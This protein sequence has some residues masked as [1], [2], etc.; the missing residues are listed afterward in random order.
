MAS[1]SSLSKWGAFSIFFW[2]ALSGCSSE[3]HLRKAIAKNP[4]ILQP[5]E[6]VLID[7]MVITPSLRVDTLAYFRTDTITIEKD[8]L[9]VQIK[10]IHDTLRITAECQSDTVRIVK[11]IALPPV[12]K[13]APRKWWE[14]VPLPLLLFLVVGYFGKRLF[15]RWANSL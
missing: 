5:K 15:D 3:W 11:E 12:I 10:R 7:T 2:L 8:R 6:I 13:Y 9:R 4:S 1:F 14:R